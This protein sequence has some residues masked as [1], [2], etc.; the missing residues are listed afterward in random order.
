M[1]LK[2]TQIIIMTQNWWKN[3]QYAYIYA[4]KSKNIENL[5]CRNR[6]FLTPMCNDE[7]WKSYS[8]M[9]NCQASIRES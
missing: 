4:N 9:D 3:L 7:Q 8:V 6:Q 5:I 1:V 2:K